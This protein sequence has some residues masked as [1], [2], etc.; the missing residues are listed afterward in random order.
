M[1]GVYGDVDDEPDR[2]DDC[3]VDPVQSNEHRRHQHSQNGVVYEVLRVSALKGDMECL[4][5]CGLILH[6]CPTAFQMDN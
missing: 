3:L 1:G 6:G 4:R 5:N 2:V